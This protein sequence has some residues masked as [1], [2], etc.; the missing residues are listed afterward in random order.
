M[1]KQANFVSS[2]VEGDVHSE[3]QIDMATGE[4]SQIEKKESDF[5]MLIGE[6]VELV[7]DGK[8]HSLEAEDN[9]LTV[10]GLAKLQSLAA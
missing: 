5:E 6:S 2:W 4:I 3:C 9:A 8:T 7:V 10:K 1:L